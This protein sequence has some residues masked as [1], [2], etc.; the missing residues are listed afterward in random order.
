MENVFVTG[1]LDL[2]LVRD[3]HGGP[4]D[5][6]MRD[7]FS[8]SLDSICDLGGSAATLGGAASASRLSSA[9]ACCRVASAAGHGHWDSDLL[10]DR[11]IPDF[12]ADSVIDSHSLL[13]L[14]V[15]LLGSANL[16]CIHG[17]GN[18]DGSLDLA[19]SLFVDTFHNHL[20]IGS[21]SSLR[22]ANSD[23]LGDFHIVSAGT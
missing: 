23:A 16:L 19:D 6:G 7:L 12:M 18:H 17:V 22:S 10:R 5:L 14:C 8:H 2:F 13:K 4:H 20:G 1:Q 21:G 15:G 11:L 3:G 9:A